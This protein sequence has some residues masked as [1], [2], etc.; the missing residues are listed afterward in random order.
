[1]LKN[2]DHHATRLRRGF[3]IKACLLLTFTAV[4]AAS[5]PDT[6]INLTLNATLN[7]YTAKPSAKG[8]YVSCVGVHTG[9]SKS[10]PIL[11]GSYKVTVTLDNQKQIIRMLTFR[12]GRADFG[13]INLSEG[14]V[15]GAVVIIGP[16]M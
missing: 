11:N 3:L 6:T 2:V 5:M 16:S 9:T 14:K 13:T 4:P 15:N 7:G 12:T 8:T 10:S 1:M